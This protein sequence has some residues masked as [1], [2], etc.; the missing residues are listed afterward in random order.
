MIRIQ[1]QAT[2]EVKTSPVS[3]KLSSM[4]EAAGAA[5]LG[6]VE[7]HSSLWRMT[8]TGQLGT[9]LMKL[10]LCLKMTLMIY[11]LV[12]TMSVHFVIEAVY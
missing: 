7:P 6:A 12:S 8:M 4:V 3:S 11:L 5:G 9:A 1:Q 2:Y 10:Q